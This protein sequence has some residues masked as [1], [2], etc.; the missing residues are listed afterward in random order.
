V[1]I[2]R[3]SFIGRFGRIPLLIDKGPEPYIVYYNNLLH[4]S[5]RVKLAVDAHVSEG[6]VWRV[7]GY[8]KARA[9]RRPCILLFAEYD[10]VYAHLHTSFLCLIGP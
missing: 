4:L 8:T 6:L 2:P 5:S 9:Y 3:L 7:C 10:I 1:R